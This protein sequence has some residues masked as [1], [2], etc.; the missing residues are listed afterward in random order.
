MT[1][2]ATIQRSAASQHILSGDIARTV[3]T[4]TWPSALALL[5]QTI[6]N[7]IDRM[8]VAHLGGVEVAALGMAQT[9]LTLVFGGVVSIS[10]ATTA[11]VAR[12][13]GASSPRDALE[14][15]RQS[16]YFA[17]L[18][19]VLLAA[20]ML[21]LARPL[22]ALMAGGAHETIAP[23]TMFLKLSLIGLLALF[24]MNV[25]ISAFRGLG[26]MLTPVSITLVSAVLTALLDWVLIYGHLGSPRMGLAGAAWAGVWAKTIAC[27]IGLLCILR[28]QLHASISRL[29]PLHWNWF[30]RIFTLGVP[31]GLQS[32]L[33]TGASMVYY[34]F[35]GRLVDG[36]AAMAALTIGLG[37]EALSYMPG[38]AFSAAAAAMVG[39]NMGAD[40]PDRATEAS[41][42]CSRQSAI[43]MTIM[44]VV[45]FVFA[46]PIVSLFTNDPTIHRLTVAYL[47][48][49]AI[50]EPFLGVRMTLSGALQGAGDTLSPT[51]A[52][53]ITLWGIRLPLTYWLAVTLSLGATAAWWTMCAS[54]IANCIVIVLQFR[55]GR[56]RT[57]RI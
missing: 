48:I 29:A 20:G 16:L 5:I 13:I 1:K 23:A 24:C 10:A 55:S 7:N 38:F 14:A 45:F 57:I 11:L 52:T 8:F 9:A 40:A 53:F 19:S 4:L 47:R 41:W 6:S 46:G 15:T 51:L 32:V 21:P 25:I 28:S 30:A 43:I 35:L 54:A 49:N 44:A 27:A 39:Q 12:Y 3:W 18:F 34:S 50:S 26:D 42:A 37:I 36:S 22:M 31:A 33:S 56:W 17:A 2:T